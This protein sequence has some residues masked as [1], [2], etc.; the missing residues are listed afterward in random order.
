[1]DRHCLKRVATAVASNILCCI[2]KSIEVISDL[3]R[4]LLSAVVSAE[5]SHLWDSFRMPVTV[6]LLMFGS[7]SWS[8]I[9]AVN[10]SCVKSLWASCNS[11]I[12]LRSAAVHCCLTPVPMAGRQQNIWYSL[13]HGLASFWLRKRPKSPLARLN[14]LRYSDNCTALPTILMSL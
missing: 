4:T 1:M 11:Q 2:L 6:G 5:F 10:F 13:L 8:A 14:F 12:L 9:S 7:F 3:T